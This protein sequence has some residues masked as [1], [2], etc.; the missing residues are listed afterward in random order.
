MDPVLDGEL[1]RGLVS[2]DATPGPS[3]R[4]AVV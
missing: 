1:F 4:M 3:F 2:L